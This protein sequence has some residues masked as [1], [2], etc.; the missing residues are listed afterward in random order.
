MASLNVTSFSNNT[1]ANA[2][3]VT[4]N[5]QN[6]KTFVESQTVQIDGSVKAGTAAIAD[7][8][9]TAAKIAA[10]AVGS[11]EIATGAVGSDELAAN[12]VTTA[13]ITDLNVTTGKIA[14]DAVTSAKIAA[15]AVTSTEL[16]SD[17]VITSKI[18]DLNVTTGKI[19]DGAITSAKIAANSVALGTATTGNYVS[20]VSSGTG[21]SV[22]H[23]PGEG[24]SA[25]VSL[26]ASL[27]N[28][29]DVVVTTPSSGQVLKYNGT[30]WVNDT[31][32]TGGVP[33]IPLDNLTD[34][35][36]TTPLS[37]QVL[38]YNGTS[39]VNDTDATG[40][41]GGGIP[42][43]NSVTSAKIVDGTIV[44]VDI[45][46]TAGIAYA[47]LA[48]SNSVV[49]SDISSS[50]GIAYSKLAALTSGNILVGNSVNVATSVAMSG[51]V[52][53]SNTGVTAINSGVIVDADVN[54]SAAIAY[55]KL[56]LN[57]SIVTNDITANAVTFDKMTSSAPRGIIAGKT[58]I[59]TNSVVVGGTA[60]AIWGLTF[61]VVAGRTYKIHFSTK[62]TASDFFD[63]WQLSIANVSNV[64][65]QDIFFGSPGTQ[66]VNGY[67]LYSPA[68]TASVTFYIRLGA[69]GPNGTAQTLA[70]AADPTWFYVEDIGAI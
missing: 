58:P 69:L 45:S 31:D 30:S 27:D 6:I 17:S 50:A 46:P 60:P 19:A 53:I 8:A 43:D 9:I 23:T 37:G 44:N 59:T 16:A 48:L 57:N 68:S 54:A 15:N 1:V 63:T 52:T 55:S 34:V 61:N 56:A 21:I 47:K 40:G 3:D 13:K 65:V 66:K 26:N 64:P 35:V 32:A 29:T 41:G 24:S 28:L 2:T 25:T 12:A 20:N 7:D 22:A 38:K 18:L 39:W 33:N 42:D 10:N 36:I 5:F 14:D 11:S 51:D 4:A 62:L 70:T 67:Y 49:N